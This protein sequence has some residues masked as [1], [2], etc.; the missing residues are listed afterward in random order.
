LLKLFYIWAI[1]FGRFMDKK[2]LQKKLKKRK[3]KE[4]GKLLD[5]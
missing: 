5:Y 4:D 3:K 2:E 1:N